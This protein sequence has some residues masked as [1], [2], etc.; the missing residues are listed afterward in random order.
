MGFCSSLHHDSSPPPPYLWGS[1]KV[2]RDQI[3]KV[4][5]SLRVLNVLKQ[6]S[7]LDTPDLSPHSGAAKLGKYCPVIRTC[8]VDFLSL[9][10]FQTRFLI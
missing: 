6:I 1:E 4:D 2:K 7:F 9:G 10:Y 5:T 3:L 8:Q